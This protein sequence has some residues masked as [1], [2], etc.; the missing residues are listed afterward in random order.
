[1]LRTARESGVY[2]VAMVAYNHAGNYTHPNSGRFYEWDQAS[3]E[4][5]MEKAAAAGMG[6]VAMKTCAGG[7][8]KEEG[9]SSPNY[10]SALRWIL[11]NPH[12]STVVPGMANF[13][14]ID[15]DVAAMTG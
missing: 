1:M 9:D 10:T 15:E 7:P 12:V 5:E 3:L 6:I 8:R 13:R 2:N 11:E 14:Q 4:K